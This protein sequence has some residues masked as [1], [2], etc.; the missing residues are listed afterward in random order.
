MTFDFEIFLWISA[1]LVAFYIKGL[2]GFANTLVFSSILGFGVNNV[3]IS[4]IELVLGYP[5]NIILT[6]KNRKSLDPKVFI[7]MAVLVVLGSILGPFF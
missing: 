1:T 6:V 5:S 4:P 7:P 3:N 2:C